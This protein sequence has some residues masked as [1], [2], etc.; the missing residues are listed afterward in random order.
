[1]GHH[2]DPAHNPASQVKIRY[3]HY[4]EEME[5]THPE[6]GSGSILAADIVELLAL[7]FAF[8]GSFVTHLNEQEKAP[9][10]RR[11]WNK[12]GN[13][14]GVKIGEEYWVDVDEDE[15]AEAAVERVVYNAA[16]KANDPIGGKREEGCR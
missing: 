6:G 16:P 14:K 5:L 11:I 10:S 8:N 15:V 13:I 12:D 2:E 4:T 7:D 1:M 9:R 3:N